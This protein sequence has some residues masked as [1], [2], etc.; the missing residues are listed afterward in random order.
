METFEDLRALAGGLEVAKHLSEREVDE[1]LRAMARVQ[2]PEYDFAD[3][4]ITLSSGGGV[5]RKPGNIVLNWRRFFELGPDL[6]LAVPAVADNRF[7]KAAF[8]LFIWNRVMGLSR[9]DLS[10]AEA[11][12]IEA[13]WLNAGRRRAL[14]SGEAF[15]LTNDL[16]RDRLATELSRRDFE[17]ALGVLS[18]AKC[19]KFENDKVTLYEQVRRRT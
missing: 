6:V 9:V 17:Q 18:T 7:T 10:E 8:G 5:S 2:P 13:L 3:R 1:L 19:I 4:L 11:S 12:V 15:T 16:R 14:P